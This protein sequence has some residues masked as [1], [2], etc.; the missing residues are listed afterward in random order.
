MSN[1]VKQRQTKSRI[2]LPETGQPRIVIVGAGF[3]GLRLARKLTKLPYQVV[4]LDTNN[5]H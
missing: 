1:N 4:L 5:Y 3:G 2:N